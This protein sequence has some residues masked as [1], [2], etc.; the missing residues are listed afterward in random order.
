ML[1]LIIFKPKKKELSKYLIV[2]HALSDIIWQRQSWN[3]YCEIS[4]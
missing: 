4:L 3:W 2:T 1:I